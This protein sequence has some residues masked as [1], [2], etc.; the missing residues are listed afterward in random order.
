MTTEDIIE[1]V[2][3]AHMAGQH[4]ANNDLD[5]ASYGDAIAYAR[6]AV[7]PK[8]TTHDSD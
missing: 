6:Y 2:A 7:V 1:L 3:Q 5:N 8:I 4:Y